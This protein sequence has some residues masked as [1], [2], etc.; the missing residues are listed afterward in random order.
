MQ[1]TR[2]EVIHIA[3]LARLALSKQEIT[4]FQRQ[5]SDILVYAGRLR[6]LDTRDIPPTTSVLSARADLRKDEP[7]ECLP[8]EKLQA[9]APQWQDGHFLVPP[10]L[11]NPNE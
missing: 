11:E 9:N 3:K 7:G 4:S 8:S 2:E 6:D 1:L 5:L 10:V